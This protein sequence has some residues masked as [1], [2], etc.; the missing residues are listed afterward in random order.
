MAKLSIKSKLLVMLLGVSLGSI[1]LV[2]TLNYIESYKTVQTS[3]FA[4]LTSLRASRADAI[5]QYVET[6][7]S[8]LE[9]LADSPNMGIMLSELSAAFQALAGTELEPEALSEL[10]TFYDDQFL[11]GLDAMVEG[12]PE[13]LSVFPESDA[14]RYLQYHYLARNPYPRDKR[15]QVDDPGD[16]SDYSRLHDQWH[17]VLRRIVNGFGYYD[18]FLIDIVSGTIVY[19]TAK[20]VDFGT[21]LIAGPHS[22][23]NLG[24]LFR[25]VQRNPNRGAARIIDFEHYR[26]SIG[27]P[28]MFI[29]A[30]VFARG[31]PVGIVAAQE[32]TAALDR[33]VTGN[34]QWERDGLGKTGETVLIGPDYLLRSASRFLIEDPEA[35]AA[36]QRAIRTPEATIQRIVQLG[37]PILEQEVRTVAAEQALRGQ[38]ATGVIVDYRGREILGSWAPL[39]LRDLDWAIVGKIDLDEAYAPIHRLARNT[40]VQT[41]VI[42]VVITV[43]VMVL[44][45]SFVRPVNDL[46]SR[47]RRFG[48]GD[49]SVEFDDDS[50]DEI[51]DLAKS[52]RELAESARKQTGMIEEVSRENE[53]LL[54]NM[55]PQRYAQNLPHGSEEA[56]ETIPEVSVIFAELRGLVEITRSQSADVCVSILTE[57]LAAADRAARRHDAERVKTMGDTYLAAVGLSSPLL[58]HIP[59]AA[60]FARE[61]RDTVATIAQS[62]EVKLDLI[63]GISAGPV[64][65]NL[66]H[67]RELMFQIWGEAVIEADFARDEA[68]LGQI[69]VTGTVR[70]ALADRYRFERMAG[71]KVVGLWILADGE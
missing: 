19:S 35:Y 50:S 26:P 60:A 33:V 64:I 42:L 2:A 63:V 49:N 4:Q 44:A 16:G 70:E 65:T 15:I 34:R 45:N 25:T 17:P 1:A 61:L 3:V 43:L 51:G 58:D 9:V 21:N 56:R 53:R 24:R 14:A 12:T 69:V 6:I 52:F 59:R 46:I 71:E 40:L 57:F 55:L 30:P 37:S 39:R 8:E 7:T 29:A 32:S 13:F 48:A 5:E 54:A 27:A 11:P 18:L 66:S 38:T 28:A 68:E 67:D 20:E 10:E 62:H 23:S 41:L 47:V 36:D 31:R 22:Q